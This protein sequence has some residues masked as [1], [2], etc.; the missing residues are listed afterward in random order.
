[1]AWCLASHGQGVARWWAR[2][3][4]RAR[5]REA[6]AETLVLR[7]VSRWTPHGTENRSVLGWFAARL[8]VC[9]S[10]WWCREPKSVRRV[11]VWGR[12]LSG[13]DLMMLGSPCRPGG[14]TYLLRGVLVSYGV[15]C[16]LPPVRV[17]SSRGGRR[18]LRGGRAGSGGGLPRGRLDL[19]IVRVRG[20]DRA[21]RVCRETKPTLV[22]FIYVGR[23]IKRLLSF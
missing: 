21:K 14:T 11:A 16:P 8:P 9:L 4:S 7:A 12:S 13:F 15:W 5:S 19:R 20:S 1:M 18:R 23:V 22:T 6:V 3:K 2:C 10:A 17:I